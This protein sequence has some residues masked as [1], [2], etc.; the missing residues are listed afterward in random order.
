MPR[1]Q[2]DRTKAK[3]R[4]RRPNGRVALDTQAKRRKIEALV[5]EVNRARLDYDRALD[6]LSRAL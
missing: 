2:Y 3:K 4:A 1:G 6:K 5:E